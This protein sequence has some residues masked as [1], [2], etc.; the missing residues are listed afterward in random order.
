[1]HF[2][3]HVFNVCTESV[4]RQAEIEEN[5]IKIGRNRALIDEEDEEDEEDEFIWLHI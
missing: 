3:P 5:V 2:L 4:I 1:M